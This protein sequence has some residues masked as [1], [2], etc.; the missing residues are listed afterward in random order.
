MVKTRSERLREASLTWN[1]SCLTPTVVHRSE[2]PNISTTSERGT[3]A[4]SSL[5]LCRFGS[6]V[7]TE[8]RFP[9]RRSM[10]I[11]AVRSMA[12]SPTAE[13]NQPYSSGFLQFFFSCNFEIDFSWGTASV[14]ENAG[15]YVT[16]V[17]KLT[18]FV[19]MASFFP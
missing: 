10:Y 15:I 5:S 18:Q 3:Q 13:K 7:E 2:G 19:E 6:T 16:K 11:V 9:N 12:E 8:V 17:E 1:S 4:N 14:L